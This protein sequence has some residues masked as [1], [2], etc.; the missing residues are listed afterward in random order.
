MAAH[1][2]YV[3]HGV[4][5]VR[6]ARALPL[7]ESLNRAASPYG[8][9]KSKKSLDRNQ[10]GGGTY[11]LFTWPM[12]S[13][14]GVP[15]DDMVS[16]KWVFNPLNVDPNGALH[17]PPCWLEFQNSAISSLSNITDGEGVEV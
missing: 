3:V 17:S 11:A 4:A 5:V 8:V 9:H 12:P 1:P 14:L 6:L 10:P 13:D 16:K 7:T 15:C 2:F